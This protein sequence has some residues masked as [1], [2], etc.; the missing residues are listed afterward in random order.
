[1][2]YPSKIF[3]F[4]PDWSTQFSISYAFETN[5]FESQHNREQRT[6]LTDIPSRKM[7]F[8]MWA[9]KDDAMKTLN[10]LRANYRQS[11]AVPVY[12][13]PLLLTDTGDIYG[14]EEINTQDSTCL[15]NLNIESGLLLLLD[16]TQVAP[17]F[18]TKI[19]SKTSSQILVDDSYTSHVLGKNIL[20]YPAISCYVD[21][22]GITAETDD[23]LEFSITF[24]EKEQF[25]V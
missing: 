6:C 25:W 20:A 18:I 12:C 10:F 13:E 24:N 2:S 7:D 9:K 14:N 22:P 5:I 15:F 3:T 21:Q 23:L 17:P 4:S 16:S 8:S 1:M 19:T 11:I